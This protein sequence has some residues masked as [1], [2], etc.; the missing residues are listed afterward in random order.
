MKLKIDIC[1]ITGTILFEY[2]VF[3]ISVSG[4]LSSINLKGGSHLP[5]KY[6]YFSESPFKMMKIAIYF[7]L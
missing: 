1:H 3:Q 5:K 4:S 2:T 7:I 6:F